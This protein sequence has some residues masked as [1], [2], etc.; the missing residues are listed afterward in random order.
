MA[1]RDCLEVRRQ[2]ERIDDILDTE[3]DPQAIER[4]ASLQCV[5]LGI[6]AFL[7]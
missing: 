3:R 1:Y 2:L 7:L 5:W 6:S 4:L